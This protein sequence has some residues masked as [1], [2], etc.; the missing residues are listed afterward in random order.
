ML[1]RVIAVVAAVAMFAAVPEAIAAE[2]VKPDFD[3][4][5]ELSGT[6]GYRMFGLVSSVDGIGQVSFFV[7]KAGEEA[8]Y[9]ARGEGTANGLD[10]DFGSLGKVDVEVRPTGKNESLHSKCDGKGKT[11]TIP[12]SEL[13]GTIE[14][15]GE[16]GFTD[17]SATS[18]PLQIRPLLNIVCGAGFSVGTTSG[19]HVGGVQLKARTT[20]SPSLLIQQNHLDARVFYEAKMH[21]KEGRVQVSRTVT[22]RLG[23]GAIRYRPSL[24][25]AF[26]TAASPFSGNATYA[27]RTAPREARTGT[28]TWRG[29]LKVDFPGHA[30]VAISGA[31]FKASIIHAHR[32]ES[33]Q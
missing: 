15:H 26:F 27:G 9:T 31:G 8:V 18:T 17:F 13:I 23:A 14:F 19:S 20:G 11:V 5:I 32:T 7:G 10:V 1:S 24:E 4:M 3:G 12:A 6:N 28:G 33:R 29:S 16:E 25:S 2:P 21:E 22:G 30:D